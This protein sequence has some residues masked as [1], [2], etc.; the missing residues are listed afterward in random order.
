MKHKASLNLQPDFGQCI[1]DNF[2]GIA[3][4]FRLTDSESAAFLF[5]FVWFLVLFCFLMHGGI[6][7]LGIRAFLS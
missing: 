4:S 2:S 1:R 3:D 6:L 5:V 7:P